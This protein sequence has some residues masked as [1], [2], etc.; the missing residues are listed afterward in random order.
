LTATLNADARAFRSM[1]WLG[2]TVE[3]ETSYE[4]NNLEI[5]A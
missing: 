3:L 4:K 1:R 2:I 5:P